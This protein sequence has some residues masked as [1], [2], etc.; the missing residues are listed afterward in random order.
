MRHYLIVGTWVATPRQSSFSL[1]MAAWGMSLV[2]WHIFIQYSSFLL[3]GLL[4]WSLVD[5]PSLYMMTSHVIIL[6]I[7]QITV[8]RWLAS[9]C[10]L[11]R[12]RFDKFMSLFDQEPC[13]QACLRMRSFGKV[14]RDLGDEMSRHQLVQ[15][16]QNHN[17]ITENFSS[18]FM[19]LGDWRLQMS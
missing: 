19:S 6:P 14:G 4:R 3:I 17:W 11:V 16:V 12:D 1:S 10:D 7:C 2:T 15:Q 18:I 5:F 9:I 13:W 8:I